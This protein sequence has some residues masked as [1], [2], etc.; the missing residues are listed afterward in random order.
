[1]KQLRHEMRYDGATPDQVYA[2]LGTPEFREAVCSYQ[3]FPRRTVS[4]TPH[5]DGMSVKVDQHR[6][7]EDV[8]SFAK[9]FVGSD[10]NIVQ[11]EEWSSPTDAALTVSIPGKPGE[12]SGTVH[13][14]GD[15]GGTT[16]TVEVGIK[17]NIPLVGGKVEDLIAGL[18][19]RALEAENKVGRKWLAGEWEP[20]G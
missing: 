19:K 12:M 10:V 16:E 2:M 18:L 4:I 20:R 15:D 11:E 17:V 14:A 7:V 9:K 13:L 1:M 6:P 8:P 5:A 3:R